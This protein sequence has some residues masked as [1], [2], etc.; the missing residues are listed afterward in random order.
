M[1]SR[2]TRQLT[3]TAHAIRYAG[4]FLPPKQRVFC[5]LDLVDERVSRFFCGA[6][7]KGGGAG[8]ASCSFVRFLRL[9]CDINETK[10]TII[11]AKANTASIAHGDEG[12]D[13]TSTT[14]NASSF[15]VGWSEMLVVLVD[16]DD[17]DQTA[18]V[19]AL[20]DVTARV[21]RFAVL[22]F[23]SE[24]IACRMTMMTTTTMPR[25]TTATTRSARP[26]N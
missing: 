7:I 14:F 10:R 26:T 2:F 15:G 4:S 1:Q 24:T 8:F 17:D 3:K 22:V 13:G 5:S 11:V 16:D 6:T 21:D 23:N 25:T 9:F 19:S 12:D 18:A 20:D